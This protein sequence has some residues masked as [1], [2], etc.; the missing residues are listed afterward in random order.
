MKKTNKQ[1]FTLVEIM[2]VVAIIG[3][4]AAIGIPSFQRARANSIAKAKENNIRLVVAAAEQYAMEN[5]V[6][7]GNITYAQY[8][9]FLKGCTSGN[10]DAL[11]VGT[12]SGGNFLA[13]A[14]TLGAT[15]DPACY[16][17]MP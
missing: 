15:S 8:Y 12:A 3:L 6:A 16:S 13:P 1:G 17:V 4:L 7:S 5:G 9:E 2:I 10:A 11:D 14:V